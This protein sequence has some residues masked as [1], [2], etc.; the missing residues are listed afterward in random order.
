MCKGTSKEAEDLTVK[1]ELPPPIEAED[2]EVQVKTQKN[3]EDVIKVYDYKSD[4][5]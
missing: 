5:V 3:S 4:T 1:I 2:S